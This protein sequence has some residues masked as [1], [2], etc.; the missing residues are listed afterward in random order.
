MGTAFHIDGWGTFLTAYHVIDF[1]MES[2]S[3]STGEGLSPC[4]TSEHPLLFLGMGLAYGTSTIP[5][6]AFAVVESMTQAM[7]EKDD[8]LAKLK[9][10]SKVES[11]ADLTVMNAIFKPK[12]IIPHFVPVKALDW[13]PSIGET[14]LAV[15]FP[16]LN[17]EQSSASKPK[18]LLSEGMYGAYGLIR[19]IHPTGTSTSNPT[20]VLEIE[21]YWPSGMSGGPVFNSSGEVIGLV[22]RS[23]EPSGD[24]PGIS[25]AT[26]FSLIPE[27]NKLCP[28]IDINNPMWRRGW[29]VLRTSPWIMAGF[30]KDN[31]TAQATAE[32]MGSEY[33][34]K[35]ANNYFGTD[36][37]IFN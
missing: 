25:Y 36:N 12:A 31:D 13:H 19:D 37:L 28:S 4:S 16:E 15:G 34:V 14:V 7:H 32:S 23:L 35:P 11:S 6:E 29:A 26:L 5:D 18:A 21:G 17:C 10:Q 9:G 2:S 24:S 22:S 33:E 30:F 8:P 1:A 20:P 3:P 27:F